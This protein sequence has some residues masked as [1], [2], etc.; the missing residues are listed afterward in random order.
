MQNHVRQS[1]R[2]TFSYIGSLAP[3]W[4]TSMLEV[5]IYFHLLGRAASSPA[6]RV[7]LPRLGRR[8]AGGSSRCDGSKGSTQSCRCLTPA[9]NIH[10]NSTIN[11]LGLWGE[12]TQ[13]PSHVSSYEMY[14]WELQLWHKRLIYNDK[15]TW[16]HL[17]IIYSQEINT[18]QR[19]TE[20]GV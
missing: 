4:G 19:G 12:A 14:T 10:I 17:H 9:A 1:V 16:K 2:L 3:L 7:P 8:S 20:S 5:C 13:S 15:K 6:S 11:P 18:Q